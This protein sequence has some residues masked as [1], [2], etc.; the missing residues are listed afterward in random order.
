MK[1]DCYKL[2]IDL[3][4]YNGQLIKKDSILYEDIKD[5]TIKTKNNIILP[6]YINIHDTSTFECIQIESTYKVGDI[7]L[8]INF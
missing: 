1:F 6:S 8:N 7:I 5:H 4:L 3:P 2:K